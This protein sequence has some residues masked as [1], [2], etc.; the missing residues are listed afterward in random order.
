[1]DKFQ[2]EEKGFYLKLVSN[3]G[4]GVAVSLY[5]ALESRTSVNVQN[6]NLVTKSKRF[7]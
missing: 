4:K 1:M 3:K 2:V 5:K 6:S 7:V